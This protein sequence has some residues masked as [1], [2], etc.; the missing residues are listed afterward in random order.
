MKLSDYINAL[1]ADGSPDP[2]ADYLIEYD[3]SAATNKK[4]LLSTLAAALSGVGIPIDGWVAAGETWT[5]AGADD[6]TFTFTIAGVDL[7]TKYQAGQRIKLTQTTPKYFI[8]TKV[9]FSADTTITVYGGTDYDLANAAIT[10][11]YYSPVKAPFGFPVDPAKWTV[12]VTDTTQR[13]QSTPTQ[14]VWYNLGSISISIPIGAWLVDYHVIGDS[15]HATGSSSFATL[16]TAN[17]TE[18]DTQFTTIAYANSSIRMSP[19]SRQKILNLASKASYYLNFKTSE[20]SVSTLYA[21]NDL[22]PLII[23]AVCAYL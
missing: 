22:T 1:S 14:N 4:L 21:R 17:N 11:P 16:S 20:T 5:Y 15:R 13:T 7:T 19:H 10:S 2:D 6:P 8:I 3:A 23:R 18:S 12:T 9:E